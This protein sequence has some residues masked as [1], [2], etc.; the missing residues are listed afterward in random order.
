MLPSQNKKTNKQKEIVYLDPIHWSPQL[1][2]FRV[3]RAPLY[4]VVYKMLFYR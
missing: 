4:S 1:F 3:L 2:N